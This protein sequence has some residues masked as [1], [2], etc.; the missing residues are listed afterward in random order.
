[1]RFDCPHLCPHT[2]L[3][4]FLLPPS[5]HVSKCSQNLRILFCDLEHQNS[6]FVWVERIL[7]SNNWTA[8]GHISSS[9]SLFLL[10]P[11]YQTLRIHFLKIYWKR[12][13]MHHPSEL[14]EEHP[15]IWICFFFLLYTLFEQFYFCN[16]FA[17]EC[18]IPI[19][20]VSQSFNSPHCMLCLCSYMHTC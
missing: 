20:K 3:A 19:Y 9:C 11:L 14:K 16:C 8:L 4:T 10:H 2:H 17:C 13:H 12:E 7:Q 5:L 6:S 18:I 15:E 1:M